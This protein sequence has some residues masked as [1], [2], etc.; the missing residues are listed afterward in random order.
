M[1]LE[2]IDIWEHGECPHTL[3]SCTYLHLPFIDTS[4][5]L[6]P[7]C[8][9]TFKFKC[10]VPPLVLFRCK[11]KLGIKEAWNKWKKTILVNLLESAGKS[12]PQDISLRA[13]ES[14]AC[15]GKIQVF[16]PLTDDLSSS[17]SH[18]SSLQ[19]LPRPVSLTLS[20][21]NVLSRHQYTWGV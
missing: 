13:T 14:P 17:T 1:K 8:V 4:T 9:K 19:V 20:F 21:H 2:R 12:N 5:F 11:L 3:M 15:A 16:S 10:S 7:S 18:G 6:P